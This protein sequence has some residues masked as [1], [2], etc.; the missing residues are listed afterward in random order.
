MKKELFKKIKE[1]ENETWICTGPNR[2]G[3]FAGTLPAFGQEVSYSRCLVMA[4][5]SC[6]KFQEQADRIDDVYDQ[7]KSI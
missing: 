4:D 3:G 5:C 2:V 7:M 1:I 6:E